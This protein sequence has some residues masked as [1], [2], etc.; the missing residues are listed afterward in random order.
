MKIEWD[1]TILMDDGLLLRADVFRPVTDDSYP[2]IL[3]YGPYGKGLHFKDGYPNAWEDLLRNHPDVGK[4]S[5]TKYMTWETV[6]PERWIPDGYACVRVDSRGM[7][8]SPGYFDPYSPRETADLYQCIEWT[9]GQSWCNGNVGLLGISYMAVNQWQVASLRPPHLRAIIPWE[10]A[11]DFYRESARHGGILS[12]F[13]SG[14]YKRQCAIMQHGLGTRSSKG[15]ITNEYVAGPETMT[16]EELTRNR[17]P[18][19]DD[20]RI[21]FL[22]DEYYKSRTANL[23]RITIPLLSCANWGGQGLHGRGNFEGF[24]N[25][26]SK[27]KWLEV[28]GGNHH[29]GFYS[30]EGVTLQK[31]FFD[32]FLKGIEND[33]EIQ[34]PVMLNIRTINGFYKRAENEWPLARTNWTKYY[35]DVTNFALEPKSI[36]VEKTRDYDPMEEGLTFLARPMSEDTEITGPISA[37]IF[38]SSSTMDADV[39]LILRLFDTM[40]KEI[41]FQGS[42]DPHSPI[43]QGWLRASHRGLDNQRSTP[44]RPYHK[45]DAEDHLTPGEITE[46][47]IEIWPTCIVVPKGYR[48][49]LT[50]QGKD[51]EY[52]ESAVLSKFFKQMRGSGPFL[53]NDPRDRPPEIFGGRVSVHSGGIHQSYITLPVIPQKP[54]KTTNDP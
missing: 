20:Y 19:D 37:R 10:G 27:Q 34:P 39:F 7:G 11:S 38:L 45:H 12:T 23:S 50:I 43:G 36:A 30:I 51:Y 3:S 16:E 33:W 41:V 49:A 2:A 21:H 52:G 42:L 46:L 13:R 15:L 9:A 44:Y 5:S 14:W 32:R 8:R 17:A 1:R 54:M 26:S 48:I 6:D 35:I 24:L 31:R 47:I 29:E 18:V 28:H 22:D 40:D 53:H 25:A 4:L